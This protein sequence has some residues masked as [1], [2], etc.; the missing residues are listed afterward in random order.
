MSQIRESR[1]ADHSI[2]PD[3]DP[4]DPD[5]LADPYPY[6]ARFRTEAPVFYAPKIYFWV[7]SRYE[8]IQNIV[9]GPKTYANVRVQEPC[10][11]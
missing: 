11:R 9:K 7:V 2:N 10:T 1:N 4:L 5:Y 3:F 6:F 8:D